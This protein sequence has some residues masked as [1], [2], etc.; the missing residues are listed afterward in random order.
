MRGVFLPRSRHKAPVSLFIERVLDGPV[1]LRLCRV[2]WLHWCHAR[3]VLLLHEVRGF[4]AL[5]P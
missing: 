4:S 1:R 2:V 3:R 5:D